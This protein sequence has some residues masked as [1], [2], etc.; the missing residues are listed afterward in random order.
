MFV[1]FA[2]LDVTFMSI[3]LQQIAIKEYKQAER[4]LQISRLKK[5]M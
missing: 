2:C 4:G 5:P 3:A 1:I